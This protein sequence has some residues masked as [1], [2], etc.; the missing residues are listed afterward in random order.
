MRYSPQHPETPAN[1][2]APGAALDELI[3]RARRLRE[4]VAALRRGER[5]EGPGHRLRDAVWELAAE[6]L[7]A[8]A[9]ELSRLRPGPQGEGLARLGER[10][11]NAE[12]N[13]LTDGVVWS[14]ELYS[15]F[16]RPVEEGPLT[17]DQLPSC[18][19][20][21]DQPALTGAVTGCLVDGRPV[22]CEFRVVRP[23]GTL[24]TVQMV[25]EPVFDEE[26]GTVAMWAMIRDLSEIR[27]S[28]ADAAREE[29]R[30]A[31]AGGPAEELRRQRR[32]ARAGHGLAIELQDQAPAPWL[33][34][35][36]PS[37]ADGPPGTLDLAV[38]YLPA[39][40][41]VPSSGKWYDTL[42][43]PDGGFVLSMGDLS[44]RGPAAA[45]GT[46]A[47][48]GAVRGIAL[49]GAEPGELLAHLNQLLDREA[50]PVLASAL[51]CRYEPGGRVLTWAQAGHPAPMLCR[52]GAGWPLPRPA[53][54]LLG[55]V[56]D[57]VYAQRTD[58]LE[59]GDVL[60]LHTDGLFS[61]IPQ[62]TPTGHGGDLRLI[63]L[64]RRLS[65]AG[66][67]GEGLGVIAAECG[68]AGREDDACVLVARV[69]P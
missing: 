66:S 42:R 69:R 20:P 23:D 31:P 67:A 3:G 68:E 61:A 57:A 25:G 19:P 47:A 64:A 12:W 6:G 60:V 38:R 55:A 26:G 39:A 37:R 29:G 54:T 36:P 43:L 41:G 5:D 16:G 49:T 40:P 35:P 10:V 63:S 45:V 50:H 7:S 24:R 58:L 13:L 14:D 46:A 17:L 1:G 2:L 44:G 30:G 18:L 62:G 53:G 9:E 32:A 8:V 34:P 52:A 51:C 48:L 22:D 4:D 65:A 28:A 11:G 27:R 15:I 33:A 59:P 56:T 21:E